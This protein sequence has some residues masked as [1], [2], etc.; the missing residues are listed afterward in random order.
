MAKA[1]R[2]TAVVLGI[3]LGLWALG[4][5]IN[6]W[7]LGVRNLALVA[8]MKPVDNYIQLILKDPYTNPSRGLVDMEATVALWE[9]NAPYGLQQFTTHTLLTTGTVSTRQATSFTLQTKKHVIATILS[10]TAMYPGSTGDSTQLPDGTPGWAIHRSPVG[11]TGPREQA[12]PVQPLVRV[13]GRVVDSN[14]MPL[15]GVSVTGISGI[16]FHPFRTPQAGVQTVTD[17]H[18]TYRVQAPLSYLGTRENPTAQTGVRIEKPGYLNNAQAQSHT[19]APMDLNS[20]TPVRLADVV[21]TPGKIVRG[22]VVDRSRRPMAKVLVSVIGITAYGGR[23]YSMY[24]TDQAGQFIATV[25][26]YA[27]AVQAHST[28]G[29]LRGFVVAESLNGD[30]PAIEM[31][32]PRTTPVEIVHAAA[33]NAGRMGIEVR[34]FTPFSFQKAQTLQDTSRGDEFLQPDLGSAS[35]SF[36]EKH[37][38][39]L[40]QGSFAQVRA[41]SENRACESDWVL[42]D[43]AQSRFLR[44]LR[45]TVYPL[46]TV[47]GVV[48]DT[49]GIPV[50]KAR[51]EEIVKLGSARTATADD[52]GRFTLSGISLATKELRFGGNTSGEVIVPIPRDAATTVTVQLDDVLVGRHRGFHES[53]RR[54]EIEEAKRTVHSILFQVRDSQT[55]QP[56]T[57]LKFGNPLITVSGLTMEDDETFRF[58]FSRNHELQFPVEAPGYFRKFA[59]FQPIET[60][61]ILY[62]DPFSHLQ[63]RVVD[64]DG[65]PAPVRKVR[66][67]QSM[68]GEVVPE[69]RISPPPN[70]STITFTNL[71]TGVA[72]LR[73]EPEP[74]FQP[75]N[76]S[77]RITEAG[78]TTTLPDI[79]VTTGSTLKIQFTDETTKS[80]FVGKSVSITVT[81]PSTW[82]TEPEKQ[83]TEITDAEG[84]VVFGGLPKGSWEI[85]LDDKRI[86]SQ[87]VRELKSNLIQHVSLGTGR[88][89]LRGFDPKSPMG[90]LS[91]IGE[92][93]TVDLAKVAVPPT[94]G[95]D[96]EI[97]DLPAG[98][99]MLR[100]LLWTEPILFV[101]GAPQVQLTKGET[102]DLSLGHYALSGQLQF[103]GLPKPQ[104]RPGTLHIVS[105]LGGTLAQDSLTTETHTLW[106]RQIIRLA[107]PAGRILQRLEYHATDDSDDYIALLEG[108]HL[109]ALLKGESIKPVRM[110]KSKLDGTTSGTK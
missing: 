104:V 47:S 36:A 107:L 68:S 41:V 9:T 33:T 45:L 97:Q 2:I 105:H 64:G 52:N 83:A 72:Y 100:T 81:N 15:P 75:R 3:G 31:E 99:Y 38:I 19:I 106:D 46:R 22:S 84:S 51:V 61:Q 76:I 28:T 26:N 73:V 93:L 102:R 7:L 101:G 94:A 110:E 55:S 4:P 62:L 16:S 109:A 49:S 11:F 80:P 88:I 82:A 103:S 48:L 78:T 91:L 54:Q 30:L 35:P 29:D 10:G 66:L 32:S 34:E 17:S 77:I 56:I 24:T 6:R 21:M 50:A 13:V 60:T 89:R 23:I 87:N 95:A 69:G 67:N 70:N 40:F 20:T 42:I 90:G 37:S 5:T 92:S 14:L 98:N 8:S 96:R 1:I 85:N 53:M 59:E 25:P 39:T 108:E 86:W 44:S 18:G 12:L 65:N 58:P 27:T 63:A 43:P 57:Q 71:T 79:V 74:P